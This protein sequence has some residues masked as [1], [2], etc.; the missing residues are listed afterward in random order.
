[1]VYVSAVVQ[2]IFFKFRC[3]VSFSPPFS[4]VAVWLSV[5]P[6]GPVITIAISVNL[7]KSK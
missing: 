6:P 7:T 1:M 5:P 4:V 2:I 3:F